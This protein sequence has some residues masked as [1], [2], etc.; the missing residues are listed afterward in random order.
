MFAQHVPDGV[1]SWLQL[2]STKVATVK[3]VDVGSRLATD[4]P[5]IESGL[6][7]RL[8]QLENFALTARKPAVVGA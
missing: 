1:Q 8:L 3:S 5:G 6:R 7:A 4:R 2:N